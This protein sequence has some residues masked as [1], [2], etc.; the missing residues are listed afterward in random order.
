MHMRG[1]AASFSDRMHIVLAINPFVLMSVVC[2]VA[3]VSNGFRSQL[4]GE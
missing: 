1:I 3:A 4:H 2:G